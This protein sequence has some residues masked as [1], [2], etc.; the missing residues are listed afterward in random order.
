MPTA[1]SADAATAAAR[2]LI[3]ALEN[4]SPASPLAPTSDS[5]RAALRQLADIFADITNANVTPTKVEPE[6]V[7]LV[8]VETAN[9]P[10]DTPHVPPGF[11]PLAPPAIPKP[12]IPEPVP[13]PRV[14]FTSPPR[15]HQYK[16]L[17][18]FN[19]VL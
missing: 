6:H 14:E 8:E 15:V 5:Q 17:R 3:Y 10:T 19:P 16:V 1:S 18:E 12:V 9:V 7:P 11:L 13:P 4:P 2:D